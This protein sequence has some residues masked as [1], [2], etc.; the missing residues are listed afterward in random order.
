MKAPIHGKWFTAHKQAS[1]TVQVKPAQEG[2]KIHLIIRPFQVSPEIGIEL[3]ADNAAELAE[4]I[5][6]SLNAQA[7]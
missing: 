1:T 4:Q 6:E 2:R 3:T 7:T 5:M